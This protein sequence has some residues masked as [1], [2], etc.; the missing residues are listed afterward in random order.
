MAIA[1][2]PADKLKRI[3][4]LLAEDAAVLVQKYGVDYAGGDGATRSRTK[5]VRRWPRISDGDRADCEAFLRAYASAKNA[6]PGH[7]VTD[8]KADREVH[9]GTWRPTRT[10]LSRLKTDPNEQGVY[11][12]LVCPADAADGDGAFPSEE[13]HLNHVH[14]EV[15]SGA[16][17]AQL[18]CGTPPKGK[19]LSASSRLDRE[20][21]EWESEVRTDEARYQKWG[22]SDGDALATTEYTREEHADAPPSVP[23]PAPGK[24]VRASADI[25]EYGTFRTQVAETTAHEK[26]TGPY[27]ASQTALQSTTEESV[28][29]AQ[30]APSAGDNEAVSAHINEFG[31]VDYNKRK[32]TPKPAEA[33]AE[34]SEW[35]EK[36][37][38]LSYQ[39]ADAGKSAID[40]VADPHAIVPSAN[41]HRNELGKV[42]GSVQVTV[43]VPRQSGPHTVEQTALR[44]V[45]STFHFNKE[46]CP[47]AT[48]ANGTATTYHPRVNKF[49]LLDIEERKTSPGTQ[50]TNA[51]KRIYPAEWWT[52]HVYTME[53]RNWTDVPKKEDF[54]ARDALASYG[55]LSNHN[56]NL[57]DLDLFDGYLVLTVP[58]EQESPEVVIED[59][60][61]RKIT[62]QNYFNKRNAPPAASSSANTLVTYNARQ[63]R[64]GL[65]DYEKRTTTLKPKDGVEYTAEDTDQHTTKVQQKFNQ[66]APEQSQKAPGKVQ[67]VTNR[68]NEAGSYDTEKR[69]TTYNPVTGT[70]YTSEDAFFEK[71][72]TRQKFN[73]TAP[74]KAQKT[75]GSIQTVHNRL[76]EAGRYDSELR[77]E[78]AE[79]QTTGEITIEDNPERKVTVQHFYNQKVKPSNVPSFTTSGSN[80]VETSYSGL[81]LNRFGL[82]DYTK[83][84]TTHKGGRGGDGNTSWSWTVKVAE[85]WGAYHKTSFP[86]KGRQIQLVDW[87]KWYRTATTT[88]KKHSSYT[89]AAAELDRGSGNLL[90]ASVTNGAHIESGGGGIFYSVKT[91]VS[92]IQW[93]GGDND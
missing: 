67:T 2:W 32:T 21:G 61:L 15:S 71:T 43:P 33:R 60:D 17:P 30:K 54:G 31:L 41:A 64:F 24:S 68:V 6:E 77:T 35:T 1:D 84:K 13:T 55:V 36:T 23:A 87:R 3:R 66:T 69:T 20:T 45:E 53:F 12:T 83:V 49:G 92:D 37:T 72:K 39:N 5:L 59:T 91:T 57:N 90:G 65:W 93:T 81:Q 63:N 19:R 44:K 14:T 79:S 16:A 62:V 89:A 75:T 29:N 50:G 40:G 18:H 56:V 22:Y 85:G 52:E 88:V 58:V 74:E 10:D 48:S 80:V 11:Q 46:S 38:S 27:T 34:S 78:T 42:D 4:A 47:A 28:R 51:W 70:E 7:T 8:P 73:Q 9:P 86:Y 25:D 26:S 82:W 76:N